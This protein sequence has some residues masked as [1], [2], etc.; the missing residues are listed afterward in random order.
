MAK[1]V[2]YA[3]KLCPEAHDALS[4]GYRQL[5]KSSS[6]FTPTLMSDFHFV[7]NDAVDALL[8]LVRNSPE[9]D[10]LLY[11]QL[12]WTCMTLLSNDGPSGRLLLQAMTS[13]GF[14]FDDD[15]RRGT[16]S[17][18]KDRHESAMDKL[19]WHT[20]QIVAALPGDSEISIARVY[21][22]IVKNC[23]LPVPHVRR[24]SE[25]ELKS[26]IRR[27]C[28]EKRFKTMI[29]AYIEENCT[30]DRRRLLRVENDT[31]S[32]AI[33]FQSRRRPGSK[34]A[35]FDSLSTAFE[36]VCEV[37]RML[38]IPAWCDTASTNDLWRRYDVTYKH[39]K[40]N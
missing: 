33:H 25:A 12:F 28:K 6:S 13:V 38:C 2:W 7:L 40:A 39:Q 19:L 24:A 14:V 3:R 15:A 36:H 16:A 37:A 8:V 22:H 1:T 20:R 9:V 32:I 35:F 5:Y 34:G 21:N 26:M 11:T 10:E 18:L 23:V 17:L 4:V 29:L 30:G 31:E 27:M